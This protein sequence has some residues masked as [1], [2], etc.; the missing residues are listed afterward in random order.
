MDIDTA[1]KLVMW[2]PKFKAPGARRRCGDCPATKWSFVQEK[3]PLSEVYGSFETRKDGNRSRRRWNL[4]Q[5]EV[6]AVV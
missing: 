4:R 1:R 5:G 6:R 3:D 2:R